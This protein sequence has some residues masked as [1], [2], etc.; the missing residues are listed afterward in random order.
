MGS[1]DTRIPLRIGELANEFGLN[2]KTIRY[3]EA[4]GLLP[5]PSR[6]HVGYRRYGNEDRERLQFIAKAK[7]L[8]LSLHQIGEI[9][10]I[11]QRGEPP[12]RHVA[13]LLDQKLATV[14]A[15]IRALTDLR[16]E[17]Q[18]L[19]GAAGEM[20]SCDAP[21]CAIIEDHRAPNTDPVDHLDLPAEWKV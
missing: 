7:A 21:I 6:T 12:C 9:F 18:I 2:P 1:D 14:D 4:I 3:Y 16:Q 10:A 19:R 11:R 17:L 8:G 15:R 13:G 5:Q 20:T